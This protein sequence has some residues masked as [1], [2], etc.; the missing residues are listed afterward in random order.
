MNFTRTT[1]ALACG[2]ALATAAIANRHPVGFYQL[3][4]AGW[5]PVP[6][7]RNLV[8]GTQPACTLCRNSSCVG[9]WA[10]MPAMAARAVLSES[11]IC[12]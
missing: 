3:T 6:G 9:R 2:L 11:A 5:T 4:A 1:L 10:T 8:E 7:G 12:A